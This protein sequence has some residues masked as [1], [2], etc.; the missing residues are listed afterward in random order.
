MKNK[1]QLVRLTESDLHNLI[2]ECVKQCINEIGDTDRG[3]YMLG[4]LNRRSSS[5]GSK[6]D[7]FAW[8]NSIDAAYGKNGGKPSAAFSHGAQDEDDNV[9]LKDVK[10]NYEAYRIGD[11]D[12]LGKA[13]I[14]FIEH[15]GGGSMLQTIVD[16]ESGNETGMPCSPLP[17]IIPEFEASV[18][19]H[20]ATPEQRKAIKKAYN[21][22]W[23]Y[24]QSQLMPEEED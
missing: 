23:Y 15:N 21:E 24:A 16:F 9:S 14:H 6:P 3:Q 1:K 19:G 13:F 5:V 11:N 7:R 10:N 17:T 4:R 22:W 20:K 8:N 2:T 12:R 18:L